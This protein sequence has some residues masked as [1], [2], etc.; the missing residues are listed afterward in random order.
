MFRK[1]T[2]IEKD[3]ISSVVF[4][5]L[6]CGCAFCAGICPAGCIR[7]KRDDDRGLYY[8]V[9]EDARC[10]DCGVCMSICP[11]V[12]ADIRSNVL[13]GGRKRNRNHPRLGSFHRLLVGYSTNDTVHRRGSSGGVATEM[14]VALLQRGMI[15]GAVVTVM[16]E[17][18]PLR[19]EPVIARTVSEILEAQQSKYCPVPLG[20]V[21][22]NIK[23]VSGRYAIVGLPCHM[24]ALRKIQNIDGRLKKKLPYLIGL[25]CSRTPSFNATKFLLERNGIDSGRVRTIEYRS[26]DSHVGHMAVYLKNGSVVKIPH[27]DFHYWGQMFANFFIPPRCYLCVDKVAAYADISVGDNWSNQLYHPWGTSTVIVRSEKGR[28]IIDLLET[29]KRVV[30]KSVDEETI[31]VSQDLVRKQDAGPK[32][33]WWRITGG[34]SPDYGAT[35]LPEVTAWGIMKSFPSFLRFSLSR[36]YKNVSC[37][38]TVGTV[39]SI[40]DRIGKITAVSLEILLKGF[41]LAKDLILSFRP[42]ARHEIGKALPYKIILIGG[43]GSRDIGDEAMPHTDLIHLRK[44]FSK[45]LE[46]VM[47]SPDPEYTASFH[48]EVSV[49]DIEKIGLSSRRGMA[50]TLMNGSKILHMIVFLAGTWLFKKGVHIQLWPSAYRGLREIASADLLFNVGGGNLNSI[51][52]EEFYKKGVTYMAASILGTPIVVSGQTIGPFRGLF[53]RLFARY[54]LNKPRMIT[55]RDKGISRNRC[56]A[57]GITKPLLIDAADDAMCLP[58]L[59]KKTAMEVVRNDPGV[60]PGWLNR[61]TALI[62]CMN[63]KGSLRLFTSKGKDTDLSGLTEILVR[64]ADHILAYYKAKIVFIPTDYHPD[65]DDRRLHREIAARMAYRDY[66]CC[67]EGEYDDVTLKGMIGLCDVA[68]GSRYHFCVFAA[69]LGIPFLGIASGIYQMTKLRGLSLLC[70]TPQTF[71]ETDLAEA[72]ADDLN[73]RVDEIIRDRESIAGSL[74]IIVP[75]L[76]KRSTTAVE[77]A[78]ELLERGVTVS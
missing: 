14:L 72:D 38:A 53:D 32:R 71:Y 11:G 61:K 70:G 33:F 62:V 60:T 29:E 36:R 41:S 3:N 40:T 30:S 7:M 39:F 77:F 5:H 12:D 6:C 16:R 78:G 26:G 46:V 44:M 25:F 56:S 49:D 27:L 54:V 9:I 22:G 31:I 20:T 76:K 57:I 13:D 34:V 15:D 67:I 75:E 52:P 17:D 1:K 37:L 8:P 2:V 63:M 51:I 55:F 19:T 24:K 64:V 23:K 28:S 69:S 45:R 59:S 68:V 65:V 74:R 43:Y 48:G 66:A 50:A 21:L 58:S 10:K 42:V 4:N 35:R 47:F 18:D 73:R